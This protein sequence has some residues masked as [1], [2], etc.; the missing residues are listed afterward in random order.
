LS[1]PP[2][3]DDEISTAED[4]AAMVPGSS[5]S[6]CRHD[7]SAALRRSSA[8]FAPQARHWST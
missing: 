3:D 4:R 2:H 1:P 7:V 5:D 6:L 8:R